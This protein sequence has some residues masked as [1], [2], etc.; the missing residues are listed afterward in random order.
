MHPGHL[1]RDFAVAALVVLVEHTKGVVGSF[2]VVADSSAELAHI[3]NT[4][5]M[6]G[7]MAVHSPL[8]CHNLYKNVDLQRQG[9]HNSDRDADAFAP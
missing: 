4:G 2:V 8:P 6:V 5:W 9:Y 3:H 1:L 7:E